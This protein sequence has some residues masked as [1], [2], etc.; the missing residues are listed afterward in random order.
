MKKQTKAN[1]A[2]LI[3][4]TLIV[5]ALIFFAVLFFYGE[6]LSSDAF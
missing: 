5:F 3:G 1:T 6:P 2:F 4:F